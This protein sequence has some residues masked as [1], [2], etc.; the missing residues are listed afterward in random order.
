MT[1]KKKTSLRKKMFIPNPIGF[2]FAIGFLHFIVSIALSLY[3]LYL[4]I[5]HGHVPTLLL[6]VLMIW[7]LGAFVIILLG[8]IGKDIRKHLYR[9]FDKAG[10]L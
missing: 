9:V 2:V 1:V 8:Y 6:V 3:A 10:H 4:Y 5:V 7:L